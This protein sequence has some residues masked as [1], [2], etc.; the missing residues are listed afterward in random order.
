MEAK[1][2]YERALKNGNTDIFSHLGRFYYINNDMDTALY[3]LRQ[4][5]YKKDRKSY[6]NL[7]YILRRGE[8]KTEQIDFPILELIKPLREEKDL[9][10]SIN[11]ALCYAI[12][13]QTEKD[14]R[15]ADQIIAELCLLDENPEAALDWWR[16]KL[17]KKGDPEGHL[18]V[19]WL[20]RHGLIKDPE[21][22]TVVERMNLAR[23][24]GWD[25]PDW[26]NTIEVVKAN[27][28]E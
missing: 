12:G 1:K 4:G 13:F 26:M 5:C 2:W 8:I 17:A 23:Q 3:Y 7:A 27:E 18:V 15:L 10:G 22:M 6:T 25:I 19:G 16:D 20:A 11:L 28:T 9:Y 14:W 21:G 24:G